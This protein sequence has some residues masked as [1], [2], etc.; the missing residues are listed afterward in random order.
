MKIRVE[1]R[2][3]VRTECPVSKRRRPELHDRLRGVLV[4]NGRRISLPPKRI[5][6]DNEADIGRFVWDSAEKIR[7]YVADEQLVEKLA[8]D[9]DVQAQQFRLS[10]Q[11][12]AEKEKR[13]QDLL[14]RV[15]KAL[16][17]PS[18]KMSELNAVHSQG[19]LHDDEE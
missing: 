11:A 10:A 12:L 3:P 8:A 17:R 2:H 5:P 15:R 19:G 7:R 9:L 13:E 16:G 4:L 1:V 18:P 6:F 14:A